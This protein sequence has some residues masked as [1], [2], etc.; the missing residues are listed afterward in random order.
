M[1]TDAATGLVSGDVRR[2]N[3]TLVLD[4]LV[5]VGPS[6]RSEISDATGLTRGSVTALAQVLVEAGI[7]SE[8]EP[9]GG[10]KG[11]PLTRLALSADHIA[12]LGVQVAADRVTAL[13]V[14]LSGEE[15]HRA[16]LPHGRPMGDPEPVLDVLA[17]VVDGALAAAAAAGR[18]LADA[19]VVVLAPV[20][21][22]PARVLGDVTLGWDEVD[23][24]GGLLRRVPSLAP[25]VVRLES[26]VP[27]AAT[28]ELGALKY[29]G[30]A[31]YIKG[32]SN[33]SGALVV[34]GRVVRGSHGL[35][36]SMAH[37]PIVAGGVACECGQHGC[38]VTVAGIDA[39][40]AAAGDDPRHTRQS[41][42]AALEDFVGR[43]LDGDPGAVAA[44]MAAVPWIAQVLQISSAVAD[45]RVMVI[46][47]HWARLTPSIAVAFEANRPLIAAAGSALATEI[48]PGVLG[49]EAGLH[50]AVEAARDR[51]LD[52][53][54][55]LIKF[56]A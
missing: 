2:H 37:V 31:L 18:R 47:G 32:D 9:V 15:L 25:D 56:N 33:I 46:G 49:A 10:S 21:G 20:G 14:T 1:P 7:L 38:L 41:P 34:R 51:L 36:G 24:I 4:H 27:L 19:T 17:E 45:P 12:L 22:R 48:V 26:D 30:D 6:A 8:A 44:W 50:G 5:R 35:G 13:M 3:L 39:L 42:S 23:V 11:R 16:S 28:A 52:D 54:T 53:P 29:T 43:V 40:L 55:S